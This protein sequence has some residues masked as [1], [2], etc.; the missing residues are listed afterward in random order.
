MTGFNHIVG[1][2]AITGI[3]ASFWDINIFSNQSFV[4][5]TIIGSLLPDIDKP[6]SL[7]GRL[8]F[9][10]SKFIDRRWGH[11]TI[12]HSLI[13]HLIVTLIF[14]FAEYILNNPNYHLTFI[15]SI[16]VLVHF[17]CDMV[18]VS[19]VPLFYPFF[20]NSCVLPAN[21]ENR[22]SI[23][24]PSHNFLTS[25]FFIFLIF[26]S[27]PLMEK[28]FWLQ[29]NN[30]LGTKKHVYSQFKKSNCLLELKYSFKRD[31]NYHKG[32][33][34]VLKASNNSFIVLNKETNN[35]ITVNESDIT[36][37]LLLN[38]TEIYDLNKLFSKIKIEKIEDLEKLKNKKIKKLNLNSNL[39]IKYFLD[40]DYK[41]SDNLK[42][43]YV[44]NF[45]YHLQK[46]NLNNQI[47]IKKLEI[48]KIEK[49]YFLE[50]RKYNLAIN[51]IKRL[52][53]IYFSS[54]D[55]KKIEILEQLESLKKIEKPLKDEIQIRMLNIQIKQ[56]QQD[57]VAYNDFKIY[58]YA[59]IL[60]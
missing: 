28:G 38:K 60:K 2:V 21:P 51:K 23:S 59:Y 25:F 5:T 53:S 19:G 31:F 36:T 1:G 57:Q 27:Y 54:S 7:L 9:P 3:T 52:N 17:F 18:T 50:M 32:I 35:F 24:N 16:A 58:G 4:I 43:E 12:T 49:N 46:K 29:L 34:Y 30:A 44:N 42:V 14:Y 6:N 20:K 37:N 8:F 39:K 40:F 26:I 13:F 55:S 56:L 33:G 10:I 11:R 45:N 15:F 41:I 48:E 47:L 22:L